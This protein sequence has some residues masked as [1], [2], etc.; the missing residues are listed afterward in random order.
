MRENRP[1]SRPFY[2]RADQVRENKWGAKIKGIKVL[3][4][5]ERKV[6][7]NTFVMSNFNYLSSMELLQCSVVEQNRKPTEK[8]FTLLVERL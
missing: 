3:G 6:L 5:T 8:S 7:V 1:F 2:F 4:F